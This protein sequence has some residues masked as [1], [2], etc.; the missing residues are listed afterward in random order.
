MRIP[1]SNQLR[2]DLPSIPDISL[3]LE[4]RDEIIPIL[5]GL[6]HVFAQPV[7]CNHIMKLVASDVN[8]DSRPDRG[9]PGFSYWQ[10]VVLQ[11][12]RMG[13]NLDY[14][15]LQ[16]LSE[17]H[18]NLRSMMGVGQ[19]DDTA[20]DWRRIHDNLSLLQPETLA[21]ISDAIV[22]EGHRLLPDAATTTRADSFV[23]DTNIHYPTESSLIL[24]GVRKL[25]DICVPMANN[26][27]VPG[28][29]QH[30]YLLK[31]VKRAARAC[32][33]VAKNKGGSF[34]K[35]LKEAYEK[36]LKYS[37]KLVCLARELCL[38][39]DMSEATAA[40]VFGEHSLQAFI[41]RTEQV[42]DTAR[43]R[44]LEGETVP[45]ADKLFSVFE[46]HTQLYK[47][48]K[49]SEPIQFGRLV[50]VFEDGA[51]FITHHYVLPRDQGD[52]DV[53]VEQLK[54]V[55]KKLGGRIERASFDRGFHTPE[56]QT[57]LNKLVKH[58]CLPK[59]GKNQAALQEEEADEEFFAARQNHP[60][61]ES[62]IGALQSGNGLVRCRDRSEVGFERYLAL[63]ILGRNLHI[64][65]KILIARESPDSA[66]AA[67]RRAA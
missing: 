41:A 16:D 14:D 59:P 57:E 12:V 17:N 29:R 9:R 62:A 37:R 7:L 50:L 28:W 22:G 2:F 15:K 34:H 56:N 4:C 30:K 27:A 42:Q 58:V 32:D 23:M 52:Q 3:N 53:A 63:G 31:M 51:G 65:G 61:V 25:I 48:G 5:R 10:I 6:Q 49:A 8:G 55:Q 13:C 60:G 11:S 24:D 20:F 43:R 54:L 40:D 66:A 46:P 44:V 26:F 18:F 33:R 38:T 47:R 1:F 21:A 64:L 39:L 67:T 36:L 19:W 45:N 35:R